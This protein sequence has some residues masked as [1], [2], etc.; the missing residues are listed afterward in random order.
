MKKGLFWTM[1][2][3]SDGGKRAKVKGYEVEVPEFKPL[4][5]FVYKGAFGFWVF[6]EQMTGLRAGVDKEKLKD[7]LKLS[8]D[9]LKHYG[10]ERVFQIVAE[11]KLVFQYDEFSL[12]DE[13]NFIVKD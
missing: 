6:C 8:I 11:S 13:F 12:P 5:F 4:R 2:N 1:L 9:R 3:T 10:K 7:A